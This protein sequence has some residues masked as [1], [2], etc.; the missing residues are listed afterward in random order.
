MK[1]LF[2]LILV[3][4]FVSLISAQ[5]PEEPPFVYSA[6]EYALTF[7]KKLNETQEKLTYMNKSSSLE[8]V[9]T[10]TINGSISGTLFYDV[11]IKGMGAEVTLRYTN[12]CDEKGWIFDGEVITTSS[13]LQNGSFKGKI[14]AQ[15]IAPGYIIYDHV[16]MKK[17]KPSSGSYIITNSQFTDTEVDYT[18]FLKSK[19]N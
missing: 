6:D 1:K 18:V 16:Q 11:K 4:L 17:G 12:Y 9:G 7:F 2:A 14:Q 10:E 13:M 15:G 3:F 5:E 19:N 8:K